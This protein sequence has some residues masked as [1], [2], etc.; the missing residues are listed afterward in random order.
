MHWFEAQSLMFMQGAPKHAGHQ[1]PHA[2]VPLPQEQLFC[3][4][5][6]WGG[7]HLLFGSL[8]ALTGE[9]TPSVPPVSAA[10]HDMQP[11]QFIWLQQTWFL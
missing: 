2:W 4:S 5:H 8:P 10:R 6:F 1:P 7:M 3:P 9:H 11:P